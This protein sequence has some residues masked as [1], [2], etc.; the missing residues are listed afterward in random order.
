MDEETKTVCVACIMIDA[1]AAVGEIVAKLQEILSGDDS[2]VVGSVQSP[3]FTDLK[4]SEGT[5]DAAVAVDVPPLTLFN[6]AQNSN[7]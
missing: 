4:W 5:E 3:D 6:R 1:E 2:Q 7:R